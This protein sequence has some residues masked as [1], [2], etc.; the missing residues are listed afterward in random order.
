MKN[1]G[2]I[3][4]ATPINPRRLDRW[5]AVNRAYQKEF[6]LMNIKKC[7]YSCRDREMLLYKEGSCEPNLNDPMLGH[8]SDAGD[9]AIIRAYPYQIISNYRVASFV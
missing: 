7:P 8:I 9:Y 2:M 1:F 3:I 4:D 5:Y 6:V